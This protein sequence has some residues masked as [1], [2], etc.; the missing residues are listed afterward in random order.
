MCVPLMPKNT[1][2]LIAELQSLSPQVVASRRR[3]LVEE[4]RS[5]GWSLQDIADAMGVTKAAVGNWV[6]RG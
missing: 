1:D 5:L 2:K 3:K 4:L 6:H